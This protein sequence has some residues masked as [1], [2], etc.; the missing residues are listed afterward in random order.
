M[1]LPAASSTA[2]TC[3]IPSSAGRRV[4]VRGRGA[5]RSMRGSHVGDGSA[6][7]RVVDAVILVGGE[8]TRLRPLT[9]AR[10]KSMLPLVD[11]PFL[12]YLFQ[13]LAAAGVTRV[14]LSCGYLPDAI[15]GRFG[16]RHL[17]ACASSTPSSRAARH[18]RRDP[19]RGRRPGDRGVPGA[20][21]RRALRLR[22]R[23]PRGAPS[24]HRRPGHDRPHPGRG[25]EPLRARAHA[26]DGSVLGFLEKPRPEEIDT[27]LINAGAYVLE[28]EVLDA[29]ADD[30]RVTSSARSSRR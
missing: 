22:P 21:R 9:L 7:V 18:R 14:I 26:A 10:P 24:R 19:L 27:N 8:G 17:T 20:E 6:R 11:R 16:E 3:S 1:A 13:Q 29:I 23:Q 5:A 12:A 4:R 2:G 30:R 15:Q 25:S 28:P